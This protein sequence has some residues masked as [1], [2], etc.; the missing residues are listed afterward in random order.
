MVWIV[1]QRYVCSYRFCV[2]SC[3]GSKM[4][5]EI[6]KIDER[7]IYYVFFSIYFFIFFLIICLV[8][9]VATA[10][11]TTLSFD[12]KDGNQLTLIKANHG[13]HRHNAC[14]ENGQMEK[15]ACRDIEIGTQRTTENHLK[16]IEPNEAKGKNKWTKHR[17]VKTSHRRSRRRHSHND[18][19][20]KRLEQN[21]CHWIS[22]FGIFV[23]INRS[24]FLLFGFLNGLLMVT[25]NKSL[26]PLLL[27]LLLCVT[28]SRTFISLFTSIFL[29]FFSS[30]LSSILSL[31]AWI[32]NCHLFFVA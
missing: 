19:N 11:Q 27:R 29:F 30:V 4:T 1:C 20:Q 5:W 16:M 22:V 32:V 21:L 9:D 15:C 6:K 24:Y 12:I 18:D 3:L 25:Q 28:S 17:K 14:I 8:V 26:C 13:T 7:D 10:H 23:T 2:G 31:G